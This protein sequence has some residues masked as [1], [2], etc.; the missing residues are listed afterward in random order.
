MTSYSDYFNVYTYRDPLIYFKVESCNNWAHREK[1]VREDFFLKKFINGLDLAIFQEKPIFIPDILQSDK[2]VETPQDTN[3]GESGGGGVPSSP[4]ILNGKK[5]KLIPPGSEDILDDWNREDWDA[6]MIRMYD[7]A[8][9]HKWCIVQL[10]DDY[11]WW[12][13]FTYR[14]IEEVVYNKFDI[15]IKA[16]AV[17]T[18][19]LPRAHTYNMHDEWINLVEANAE[20][21]N[22]KGEINSLGLYVN[23]GHDIDPRIDGTDL[24]GIW[25]LSV[26]LRYILQD[27]L[28]N[29]AKSSGFYW[30]M[31]G[32]G[33]SD[34]IKEDIV[35]AFELCGTS[36]M[37]GA[38]K[39]TIEQMEAMFPKNPEFSIL[40]MDKVMKIFSGSCG[41]PYLYFNGEK[42]TG[43]IFEENSSAMAQ[44][45]DKKKEVFGVLKHYILKL[46]EMRWGIKC[47]DVFPNIEEEE[48][49][50]YSEDV[51]EK[52]KPASDSGTESE[53]KKMRLQS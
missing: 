11:P 15:P 53:L 47:D 25:S 41:L 8:R 4:N 10:Y 6:L 1:A 20:D 30:L 38:T 27:I 31:Y 16:H 35:N 40:A 9:T 19:Q 13:V 46:V 24:D 12:R 23:W 32:S 3:T 39:Q 18:K 17:W 44:V 48:E 7:A 36:H 22:E 28:N 50:Q 34:A 33:V 37:I 45:N 29:S 43:G 14:E 5:A 2:E 26:Y 21:L 42:D 52:R 51:I 49:E